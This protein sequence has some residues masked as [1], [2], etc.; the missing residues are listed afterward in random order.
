M[1]TEVSRRRSYYFSQ[2]VDQRLSSEI[3]LLQPSLFGLCTITQTQVPLVSSYE[4]Y[5]R[6][7]I[8]TI[9]R[10]LIWTEQDFP[11]RAIHT[12]LQQ[13]Y[14]NSSYKADRFEYTVYFIQVNSESQILNEAVTFRIECA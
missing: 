11:V 7:Q 9:R 8:T 4:F 1:H 13:R 3:H 12:T 2:W 14:L 6:F 5:V 10:S